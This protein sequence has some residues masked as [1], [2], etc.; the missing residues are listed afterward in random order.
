[1]QFKGLELSELITLISE[2]YTLLSKVGQIL[3]ILVSITIKFSTR[4]EH[5]IKVAAFIKYS[6]KSQAAFIYSLMSGK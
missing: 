6:T 4:Q 3:K 2:I 5:E 1:M